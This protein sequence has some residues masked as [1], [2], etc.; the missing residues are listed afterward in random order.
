MRYWAI[1]GLLACTSVG[2]ALEMDPS[3]VAEEGVGAPETVGSSASALNAGVTPSVVSGET[4]AW[5][6]VLP[7]STK[8]SDKNAGPSTTLSDKNAGLSTT[9]SDKN[10]GPITIAPGTTV[11]NGDNHKPPPMPW[12]TDPTDDD[13]TS[14]A[15]HNRVPK[16]DPTP[17][18]Q[19]TTRTGAAA[20]R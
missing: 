11:E 12:N 16:G 5:L 7:T 6:P 14:P 13:T 8:L 20:Q 4:A 15:L 1:V 19:G 18:E 17:P 10:A 3:Q 2:C 9:L